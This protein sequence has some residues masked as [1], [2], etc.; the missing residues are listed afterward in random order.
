MDQ[1][2]EGRLAAS[3]RGRRSLEA[4]GA[5][6]IWAAV[7]IIVAPDPESILLIRRAEWEGDPWSGQMALPGGRRDPAD[8][9]LEHTARRETWEEVGITLAVG[10]S[11]G[12]LDDFAPSTPVLPPVAVRPFVFHLDH[13]PALRLSDE[14]DTA[15]W[16]LLDQLRDPANYFETTVV[17]RGMELE[18]P[19]YHTPC[20][21]V[22]GL[23][24]RLLTQF[25][26]LLADG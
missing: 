19:A 25:L 12:A 16:V 14:V 4:E 17:A 6:L 11:L 24:E 22:W 5:G 20:G 21:V 2:I 3:L 15:D 7:A 10:A 1:T 18:R 8:A 26:D 13:R 9:D 23:T